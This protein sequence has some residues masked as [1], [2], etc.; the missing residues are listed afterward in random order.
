[1]HLLTSLFVGLLF[2]ASSFAVMAD[3]KDEMAK[4]QKKYNTDVMEKDFF[5]E[6]PEKVEA[7]IK[8]A[9]EKD[10]KPE[11]Y[12]GIYW[13]GG[14]TCRDLLRY[15]WRE[16]RDCRYYHRYHGRYYPYH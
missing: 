11:E 5:A 6:Q 7:Y 13:R 12:T 1:M 8:E 2:L 3:D 15:S 10:L 14:Y 16:Y 4:M 9:M